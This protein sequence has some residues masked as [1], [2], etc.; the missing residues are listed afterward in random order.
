LLLLLLLLLL[1]QRAHHTAGIKQAA[2]LTMRIRPCCGRCLCHSRGCRYGRGRRRCCCSVG[3]CC[4]V[5][6]TALP[7]PLLLQHVAR[8]IRHQQLPAPLGGGDRA[9]TAAAAPYACSAGHLERR[10]QLHRQARCRSLNK[11]PQD[12]VWR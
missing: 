12:E 9:H 7:W 6:G 1:V 10:W 5:V 2:A 3:V 4:W 11:H 8:R